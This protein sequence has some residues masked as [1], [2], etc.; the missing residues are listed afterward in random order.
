[1]SEINDRNKSTAGIIAVITA[2]ILATDGLVAEA[3]FILFPI[4]EINGVQE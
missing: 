3:S 4:F 1:M 2:Y